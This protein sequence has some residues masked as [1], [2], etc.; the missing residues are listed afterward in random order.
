MFAIVATFAASIKLYENAKYQSHST[1]EY[2]EVKLYLTL[3]IIMGVL[4]FGIA[5]V[6]IVAVVKVRNQI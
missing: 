6:L 2:H 4:N 1:P 5:T 3:A